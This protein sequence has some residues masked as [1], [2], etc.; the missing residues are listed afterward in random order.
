MIPDVLT[1]AGPGG[2]PH[3]RLFDGKTG[4]VLNEYFAFD[5]SFH[6]GVYVAL[7]DRVST[8]S[9]SGSYWETVVGAGPGGGPDVRVFK[10]LTGAQ[11][12]D[13]YAYD[14]GFRGGVR[15]AAGT[16]ID[17]EPIIMTGAGPGG[18]P[19]VKVMD[20]FGNTIHSFFAYDA[21]F[22]GGVYVGI[23]Y[24]KSSPDPTLVTGAGEGGGPHV[25]IW[26]GAT[27]QL[28]SEF[29]AYDANFHGGVRVGGS[30]LLFAQNILPIVTGA[31]PGGGP[32]VRTFDSQTRQQQSDFFAYDPSF[33][34]GVFVGIG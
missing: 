9:P 13:F 24:D 5:A 16:G 4:A 28:R 29:F 25:R 30:P 17:A 27:A 20:T 12:S 34:G 3:V 11:L 2:G 7:G 18:G 32:D 19:H 22:T 14:A 6:G 10:S 21:G 23:L 8:K 1:G 31:G 15:V 26:N 33:V